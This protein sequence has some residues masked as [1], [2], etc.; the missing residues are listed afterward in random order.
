M[1]TRTDTAFCSKLMGPTSCLCC[2]VRQT[3][4]FLSALFNTKPMIRKVDGLCNVCAAQLTGQDAPCT[5]QPQQQQWQPRNKADNLHMPAGLCA[6]QC[7]VLFMKQQQF[8]DDNHTLSLMTSLSVKVR[9]RSSRARRFMWD[10]A[11]KPC[12]LLII[13]CPRACTDQSPH[14][15]KGY[16]RQSTCT[17]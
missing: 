1:L 12:S 17:V 5:Q 2:Q 14:H 16:A 3:A 8:P 10:M 9:A 11:A 4:V 15:Q 13:C 6:W 7:Q